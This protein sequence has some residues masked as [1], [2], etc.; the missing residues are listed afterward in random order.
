LLLKPLLAF[1]V[2]AVGAA[3][4]AAG[5]GNFEVGLAIRAFQHH[6]I[7]TLPPAANHGPQGLAMAGQQFWTMQEF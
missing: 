7:T 1:M 5:M 2:L 4:M 6:Q 3:A